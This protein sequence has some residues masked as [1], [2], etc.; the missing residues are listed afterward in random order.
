MNSG[1]GGW[2]AND[3]HG[4]ARPLAGTGV[5]LG[6]L[7][8]HRQTAQVTDAAIGLDALQSLEIHADLAA[9]IAFDD[10][11]AILNGVNNLRELLLGQILG[12]DAR[13][14]I[15]LSQDDFR[16]AGADA[17][18]VPERNVDAL[19]RRDFHTNNT[20]HIFVK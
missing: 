17:V 7:P 15:R 5:G 1:L 4:L 18:N 12:P 8:T 19:V 3:T 6:A 20:S 2:T 13:I 16:V 11:L 9:Q 10:I 14:D